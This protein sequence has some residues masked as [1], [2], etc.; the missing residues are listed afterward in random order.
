MN[1]LA[2]KEHQL[3]A[4]KFWNN[5]NAV[6]YPSRKR[7]NYSRRE[8]Y[9]N[10]IQKYIVGWGRSFA[11]VGRYVAVPAIPENFTRPGCAGGFALAWCRDCRGGLSRPGIS[12]CPATTTISS[13]L[14]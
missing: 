6:K 12:S 13:K 14:R 1:C 7:R 11:A 3:I 8:R 5:S 9:D 10:D 2:T 4:H